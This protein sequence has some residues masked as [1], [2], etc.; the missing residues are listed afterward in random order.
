MHINTKISVNIEY[1]YMQRVKIKE[2]SPCTLMGAW[3]LRKRVE[4]N[5]L[6]FSRFNFKIKRK[7]ETLSEECLVGKIITKVKS[8]CFYSTH[9]YKHIPCQQA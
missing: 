1:P 8:C 7:K 9:H 2:L 6:R 3:S 5:R 4:L